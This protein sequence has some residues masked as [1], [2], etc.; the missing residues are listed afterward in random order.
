M[1]LKDLLSGTDV[2]CPEELEGLTISGIAFNSEEVMKGDVFISIKGQH[3]KAK[4]YALDAA[5]KGAKIIITEEEFSLESIPVLRTS[6]GKK[7]LSDISH[8]F[9]ENQNSFSGNIIGVTGTNGK[10][11]TCYMIKNI[12][13]VAGRNCG[14]IGTIEYSFAGKTYQAMNT[15]PDFCYLEKLLLEMEKCGVRNCVMEVSSQAIELGRVE[16]MW[17]SYGIFT[18]LT[19]DHLDF[20][21]DMSQYY[22]AKKKLFFKTNKANIINIDDAYGKKLIEDISSKT[23]AKLRSY[24]VKNNAADYT[25]NILEKSFSGTTI[26]VCH[27]DE[28]L[29]RL[30]VKIPGTY[31]LENAMAAISTACE[32]RVSFDKIKEGIETLP[33]VPGR[34]EIIENPKKLYTVIIDFAHSPDA[35]EKILSTVMEIKNGRILCLFGCGG[36]RDREKRKKMGNIVG[37]LADFAVITS[38]NPRT[39]E[40]SLIAEEIEEGIYETGCEYQ[41][42]DDRLEAIQFILNQAKAKDVVLILGKGHEK[43]QIIGEKKFFFDDKETVLKLIEG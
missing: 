10:T 29:G 43:Y 42:I 24:S 32:C 40:Q 27:R 30:T 17:F 34:F 19:E 2:H 26:E 22:E 28:V 31:M 16:G 9:Y 25:C 23:S 35:V 39:E 36:D 41:V 37:R 15:T 5:F 21:K 11:T 20:H 3:D 18:N 13:E 38:D 4:F 1:R 33:P 12:L 7:L 14:N 8:T 6:D